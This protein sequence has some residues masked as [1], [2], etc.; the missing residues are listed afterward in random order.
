MFLPLY[1]NILINL[2]GLVV[3]EHKI[4]LEAPTESPR[5]MPSD[6]ALRECKNL[7]ENVGQGDPNEQ[8]CKGL[9]ERPVRLARRDEMCIPMNREFSVDDEKS[10]KYKPL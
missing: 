10:W 2:L 3:C 6:Q 8:H 7:E 4:Q 9:S 5:E 1:R